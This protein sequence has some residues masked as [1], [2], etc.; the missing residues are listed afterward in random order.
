MGKLEE[1]TDDILDLLR[2]AGLTVFAEYEHAVTPVPETPFLTAAPKKLTCGD[3]VPYRGGKAVAV[4][5]SLVLRLH[6]PV[7]EPGNASAEI[8]EQTVLPAITAANYDIR[9]MEL[10]SPEYQKTL[11][12]MVS[13]AALVIGGLWIFLPD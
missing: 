10:R 1:L 2:N 12:R 13:E 3:T 9:S 4:T 5:L 7:S 6:L 8:M 11:D